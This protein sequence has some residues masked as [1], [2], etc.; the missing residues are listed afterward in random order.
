MHLIITLLLTLSSVVVAD[1]ANEGHHGGSQAWVRDFDN[2]VAFGDRYGGSTAIKELRLTV[3][4]IVTQM[5]V[6]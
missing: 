3:I 2:L 5:K 6:D 1:I 4:C